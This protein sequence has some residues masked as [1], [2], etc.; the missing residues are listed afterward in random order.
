[1]GVA[2]SGF[3]RG[4]LAAGLGL[5]L[6]AGGASAQ[7][8]ISNERIGNVIGGVGGAVLGS[9]IGG[10]SGRIVGGV[11]GALGGAVVGGAIGRSMDA[12]PPPRQAPAQHAPAQTTLYPAAAQDEGLYPAAEPAVGEVRVARV[13]SNVRSGPGTQHPVVARLEQGESVTV[14]GASGGGGWYL[15]SRDGRGRGYVSAPLLVPPTVDS[16]GYVG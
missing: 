8:D 13:R 14:L 2:T 16:D 9:Q 10:G 7:S 3:R 15:I 12:P 4:A 5:A 1:M 11:V 6:A